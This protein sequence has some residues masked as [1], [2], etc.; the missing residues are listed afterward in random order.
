MNRKEIYVKV[1][2]GHLGFCYDTLFEDGRGGYV[3]VTT[4]YS[5]SR[6]NKCLF[7]V[8]QVDFETN[9]VVLRACDKTV[10]LYLECLAQKHGIAPE[11]GLIK[12]LS[13]N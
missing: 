9:K 10:G 2:E 8:S 11:T 1:L 3:I 5:D 13:Q 12:A 7:E 6:A 4:S